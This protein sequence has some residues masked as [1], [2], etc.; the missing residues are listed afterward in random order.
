MN[1]VEFLKENG[2]KSWKNRW[3]WLRFGAFLYRKWPETSWLR[4]QELAHARATELKAREAAL[5]A[6]SKQRLQTEA[7]KRGEHG[8]N[9][10]KSSRNW[11]KLA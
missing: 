11:P 1:F 4:G 7:P 8:L 2:G 5:E 6:A 10:P 3:K 9:P